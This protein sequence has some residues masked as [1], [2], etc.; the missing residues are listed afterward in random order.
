MK[1]HFKKAVIFGPGL[2]GGSIGINLRKKAI[3]DIVIGVARH[4]S[5]LQKA[6][7][8]GAIDQWQFDGDMAVLDA[9]LIILATPVETIKKLIVSLS[10]LL[11][12]GCIIIDVGSTKAEI[13]QFA[14]RILP[15]SVYFVGTHP[16]AG[17]EK[18]GAEFANENLFLNS[19]CFIA[20][21]KSTNSQAAATV[22]Y[23]WKML[24]AKTIVISPELHDM[25]AAQISHLPHMISALLVE[26]IE[27]KFLRYVS[28]GFKDT[29]RIASGAPEIWSDIALSNRKAILHA[30]GIFE[31]KLIKFKSYLKKEE[32]ESLAHCLMRAK[33]KR[34][35]IG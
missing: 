15:K 10:S 4:K 16:M 23:I 32:Q 14:E 20:K 31:K 17:S 5:T 1:K 13:V 35:R 7:S 26:S 8:K 2:I 11:Q 27:E 29:T 25:I 24:G 12:N 21:T 33:N 28:T 22:N 30:I 9:D 18:A 6:K 3:A 19:F 34:D